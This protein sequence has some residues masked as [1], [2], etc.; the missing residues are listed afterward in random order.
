MIEFTFGTVVGILATILLLRYL[1]SRAI[2][3]ILE[4][5]EMETE[6]EK[7]EVSVEEIN[8]VFFLYQVNN[9]RFLGQGR[10]LEELR[11]RLKQT[12]GE[13]FIAV[14]TGDNDVVNRFRATENKTAN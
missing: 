2:K 4:Q 5:V 1:A 9:N 11:V 8:G 3:R 13:R 12:L 6:P 14:I 10:D 7:I